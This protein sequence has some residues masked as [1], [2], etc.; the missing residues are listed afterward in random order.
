MRKNKLLKNIEY[1]LNQCGMS[2]TDLANKIGLSASTVHS[3][4]QRGTENIS[5]ST[6]AKI[7]RLFDITLDELV[8]GA[9]EETYNEISFEE[10]ELL[11]IVRKYYVKRI[12]V[13][14]K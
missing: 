14:E 9:K 10:R 3:W 7:S 4:W 1:H 5:I 8:F 11:R 2:R 13:N 6:L 12:E